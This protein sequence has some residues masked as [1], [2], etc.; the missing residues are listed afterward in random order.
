MG[1]SELI[2]MGNV[3]YME[4]LVVEL[5]CRK[6]E[7]LAMYLGL[8]LGACFKSRA[9][10]HSMVERVHK[11]L[12]IGKGNI[13][14][15]EGTGL[16]FIKSTLSSLPTYHMT[17]F[18]I[19]KKVS[20]RIEKIQRGFFVRRGFFIKKNL[21]WCDGRLLAER[22]VKWIWMYASKNESLWRQVIVE[23]YREKKRGW[24]S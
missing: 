4:E 14:P 19:C 20:Y 17:L 7:L 22:N 5:G 16:T 2:P 11:R 10:W 15:R 8:L 18:V 13:F 21:T 6:G 9:G 24:C 1:K 23:K 12:T 3:P